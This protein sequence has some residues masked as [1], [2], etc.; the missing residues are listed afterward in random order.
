MKTLATIIGTLAVLALCAAFAVALGFCC[1]L[2]FELAG[3]LV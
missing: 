1:G 2:G 3:M